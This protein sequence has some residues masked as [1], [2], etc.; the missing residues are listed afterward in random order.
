[1][2]IKRLVLTLL[3]FVF[4]LHSFAQFKL[5]GKIKGYKG[6]EKLQINIPLVYGFYEENSINIPIKNDGS[7]NIELSV[8]DTKFAGLI[9]NNYK[10]DLLLQPNRSLSIN[11]NQTAK[12]IE[13]LSGTAL[14][15]NALMQ[16]INF[17]GS[18][19]FLN[20]HADNDKYY[21]QFTYQKS[22]DSVVRPYLK[23]QEQKV[24][25]VQ[26]S[27]INNIAKQIIIDDI[28]YRSIYLLDMFARTANLGKTTMD[29][30]IF[31]IFENSKFSGQRAPSGSNYY[32]YLDSYLNYLATKAFLKAK[33]DK[34]PE[35]QPLPYYGISLDS[36]KTLAREKGKW[37]VEW[38]GAVKNIPVKDIESY[39]YQKIAT[40]YSEKN[41]GHLQPL[42][43]A[44]KKQ[45]P[46][47]IYLKEVKTKTI[48]LKQ[49][50]EENQNNKNI[51]IMDG[52]ENISRIADVIKTLKGKVVYLDVWGTWC[53]PCKE[54]LQYVPELK[55]KFKD[56]NVAFVYLDMDDDRQDDFWKQFI[57][58]NRMEGLHLRKNRQ[59]IA[60]FWDELL[61]NVTD[62]SQ[63]YPRF[64]I[65]D[66]E[67]KLTIPNALRPSNREEL[68]QQI[69]RVLNQK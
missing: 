14:P 67:G 45:F 37:Y 57:K 66:K 54:E 23:Q 1:M 17:R 36:G 9:L 33:Q 41:L 48:S 30:L 24:R 6:T 31:K 60:P 27:N 11:I 49:K 65:F 38:I 12:V 40:L 46:N 62:K 3:S 4:S 39:F 28:N 8:K 10:Y 51:I 44:F 22:L 35:N 13:Y 32:N 64:F 34:I 59:T 42:A 55:A 68:Y 16:Q 47:S 43:E 63:S 18:A 26:I 61:A 52:Y 2:S 50:L 15:E 20:D 53:G 25:S 21:T 69:E 58:V 7:F 29:S 5:N 56:K 19:F